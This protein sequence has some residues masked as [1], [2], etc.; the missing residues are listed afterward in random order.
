IQDPTNENCAQCHGVVQAG[1]DTPLVIDSD[2]PANWQTLTTGQVISPEMISNSGLN[3]T[4]KDELDRAWDIHAERGLKCTDCHYSLNNPAYYQTDST[5]EHLSFDPRRLEISEYLQKP[6]H[7]FARGQSAQFT[8]APELKGTMRRCE[9]CH[10]AETTHDWLPYAK[11]HLTEVA[12]ESCHIPKMY[13]PAIQQYDWTVLTSDGQPRIEYRGVEGEPAA[14]NSLITGYT[15]TLLPRQNIDGGAMLAPYN[16]ISAWYWAY[17]DA[18]G[19]ARPVRLQDLQAAWFEN[20]NYVTEIVDAFDTNGDEQLSNAELKIDTHGKQALIAARL[21]SLGL[22]N[23]RIVGEVQPYSINHNVARGEWA[24][25]DCQTCHNAES[26]ITQPMQLA[27]YVPGGVT[28][29][30]VKDA[31]TITNGD[32]YS[33]GGAL[34]YRPATGDQNVYVFG[35][36]RVSWVDWFGLA[37]VLGVIAGI[38]A[39]GGLRFYASL[40]A[41][42]HSIPTKRVYMYA[43][44]ERFW[45]WLQTSTILLLLVTG[46]IIHRPD[47]FGL[48]N[49]KYV[50][51]IHNVVAAILVI[52]AA[53][54]L[55]YHLVSGEIKQYIPRPYGFFDQAILQA[56]FYLGGIFK[57]EP[58]PFEKSPQKK[59]NP[60]QQITYF[61]ILNVLLPLQVIT[62]ALM[63][64][65]QEWPQVTNMFGGLPFLAPFHSLVAWTFAAFIIAHVYL[66]T[67]GHEPLASMKAMMIGWDEVEDHMSLIEQPTLI[68]PQLNYGEGGSA[69]AAA[70]TTLQEEV[71]THDNPDTPEPQE[72]EPESTPV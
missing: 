36:S 40:R 14:L 44:Y 65:V 45:H 33:D 56:K 43:V 3:L 26:R 48:F 29:T 17:D 70:P 49:F 34:Y 21:E 32:L 12:C 72:T 15:P 37:S 38:S 61:G 27:A 25:A 11:Q 19:N 53:L 8:V 60:L 52:N 59:L 71:V 42:R 7:Q 28:P 67:T 24:T 47:L 63:W 20:G 62:G 18:N 66:T 69:I 57:R 54:S 51:V 16:L 39:H 50:V 55:F 6:V 1:S 10:T 5:L 35:H 23:P 31:N 41:R 4:G 58:H 64:S 22:E 9:S 46:L 30:F 2:S 13:A 68:S